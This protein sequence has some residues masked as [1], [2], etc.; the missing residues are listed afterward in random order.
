MA[1]V[2]HKPM[3]SAHCPGRIQNRVR[4]V[5]SPKIL[6]HSS[7]IRTY[8]TTSPSGRSKILASQK[9]NSGGPLMSK[10]SGVLL[11]SI[12]CSKVTRRLSLHSQLKRSKQVSKVQEVQNEQ[13]Y[14]CDSSF[15]E[16]QF[17]CIS[18]SER[19]VPAY[20]HSSLLSAI[21]QICS[22]VGRKEIKISLAEKGHGHIGSLNSLI[23]GSSVGPAPLKGITSV[24]SKELEQ[25]IKFPRQGGD[26]SSQYQG[27]LDVVANQEA[28]I[29][30]SSLELS[31]SDDDNDGCQCVGM[32]GPHGLSTSSGSV[33]RPDEIKLLQQQ[34]A[35]SS[36]AG[37]TVFQQPDPGPSCSNKIRQ[38][39]CGGL[40]EP[41]RRNKE[42]PA[43][44]PI[45]SHSQM[46]GSKSGIV[47]GSPLER[48]LKSP[49]RLVE[50][51]S[52]GS[53]RMV[54]QSSD[55][56]GNYISL[57]MSGDRLIRK[58]G[59]CQVSEVLFPPPE[60]QSLGSGRLL[61][62]LGLPFD[63]CVSSN[64][65]VIQGFEQDYTGPS[66]SYSDCAILAKET[67]VHVT[68]SLEG[69][70]TNQSSSSSGASV[71][72]AILS[73]KSGASASYGLEPE[74]GLLKARGFSDELAGTLIQSRKKVTRQIYQKTWKIFNEWCVERSM[75]NNSLT[76]VLEFLQSGFQ[77]G[78]STSTLKVQTSAL[79][80]FLERRLAQEELVIRFFEALKRIKPVVRTRIPPWDLNIV[81][82]GL[83]KPP[84]EPLEQ[85]SDKFLSL[86]TSFLLAITTARRLGELQ[87]LSIKEPYCVVSE[88]R[89]TLR[90]DIAFL[91]KV[92]SKFHRSQE[93]FI[94][95]F[96]DNPANDK[97]RTLHCLDVRRCLL[98]YLERTKSW[99]KTEAMFVIFSGNARGSKASK[100]TL[101]RW[102]KQAITEAYQI[103][104]RQ[105]SFPVK[106]H[107]TRAVS[108]SWAE[109]A[110][111]SIEQICRAATWSSQNTFVKHY[112]LNVLANSDLSFGRKVLQAV[113]P[114]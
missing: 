102:I 91:P 28:S 106:A 26:D 55:S 70:R 53:E 94:P 107:S 13:H 16:G 33:V 31:I 51:E 35:R 29:R 66:T 38:Q 47:E 37:L 45:G 88:D 19:C 79:S 49:G 96:C 63:V 4:N 84:F 99:R 103:Q 41:S 77:K 18:G 80:V 17:P 86:K 20:S 90:L 14:F 46:G 57:G 42:S 100:P 69:I 81:L 32:G 54:S 114:P 95:S 87:A 48:D 8:K 9:G 105:L 101:A 27:I 92:V 10:G 15:T 72:G 78:L 64:T 83:C 30:G 5:T 71:S 110:G 44:V 82:Q 62:E 6:C 61:S 43:V 108:T 56:S 39:Q 97:E 40:C 25:E 3:A 89:I 24:D 11:S 76:S 65:A 50:S 2:L 75:V 111:A 109:R 68:S 73:S 112:R 98:Q 67:L 34:G 85:A 113:V 52:F 21:P 104:G 22:P 23:P 74:W 58:E 93:L 7:A 60:R 59:E 12:S 1:S 36:M